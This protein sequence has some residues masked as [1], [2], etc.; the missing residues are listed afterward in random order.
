MRLISAHV[1]KFRNIDDSTEVAIR[2]DVTCLV[3]KN[4]SGKTAFLHALNRLNPSDAARFD[5]L[6]DYPR[7]LYT[8]DRKAGVIN[9]TPPVTAVFELDP[10]DIA[11]IDAQFGQGVVTTQRV[12]AKRFYDGELSVTIAGD[13]L[14]E[15]AAV[16]HLAAI[17]ELG[18]AATAAIGTPKTVAELHDA[19]GAVRDCAKPSGDGEPDATLIGEADRLEGIITAA[20]GTA[21]LTDAVAD[22]LSRRLPTFFYFGEYNFLAGRTDLA[23][24]LQRVQDLTPGERTALA[25]LRLAGADDEALIDEDYENRKAELEAV[26]N[27]L[28]SEMTDYWSQSKDLSVEIDVDKKVEPHPAGGEHIVARYLDVRVKDQ[29]HGHT[30]N[31]E[32]RSSGFRWFFSFLAAFSEYEDN[33]DRVIILLDEPALTLHAR[34]Q[35]DFLRFINERLASKHQVLFTTHSP[36]MVDPARLERVRVVEDQGARIGT[37][38]TSD[39][40][41]TDRDTLFPL[42]A[43]LGYDIAQSLFVGPNNLL[44]EGTSDY[45]YL[46]VMSDHLEEL[47]R[48]GLDARWTMVPVGGIAKIGT[49]VALL[50]SHLDVTVLID[51]GPDMKQVIELAKRKLLDNGRIVTPAMVTGT[52][53]ADIEDLFAVD[54]YLSLYNAAFKAAVTASDLTGKDRIVRRI[55]RKE[56]DFDHGRPADELLRNRDTHLANLAPETLDNFEK[57]FEQINSTR[58]R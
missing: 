34:A 46:R 20:V 32:T 24:V 7:W 53:E 26:A 14:D 3:G 31:F 22:A 11:A 17:A 58:R 25:L 57:L 51:A 33:P 15:L 55:A 2:P 27:E 35:H 6:S 19:I 54:D 52:K 30:S 4:E 48:V 39:A 23:R 45:T 56:Q 16:K 1:Q 10:E 40:L 18:P 5:A 47:G 28:T 13:P 50:G 36:F 21:T 37:R 43:A 38:V 44:L 42:Q 9:D 49:F 12:V 41:S 8:K 29:R